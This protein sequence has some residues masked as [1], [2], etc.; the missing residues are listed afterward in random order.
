MAYIMHNLGPLEVNSFQFMSDLLK[1]KNFLFHQRYLLCRNK[2]DQVNKNHLRDFMRNEKKKLGPVRLI[3]VNIF[4][5]NSK[6]IKLV[7]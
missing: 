6:K 2:T 4:F 5:L 3:N 7:F 1:L